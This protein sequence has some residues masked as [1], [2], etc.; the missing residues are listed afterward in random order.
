MTDKT[1]I[2]QTL[3]EHDDEFLLKCLVLLYRQ[4]EQDEQDSHSTH[5]SNGK[6]FNKSDAQRLSA[7]AEL[8]LEGNLPVKWL[9]DIRTRILKYA[10]QLTTLLP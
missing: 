8:H 6:G 2:T 3:L 9:P 7:A 5:H 1:L 10:S 4:Q